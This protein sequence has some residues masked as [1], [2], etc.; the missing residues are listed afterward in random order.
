MYIKSNRKFKDSIRYFFL[1]YSIIPIVISLILFSIFAAALI[2]I[3]IIINTKQANRSIRTNIDKIY[4]NYYDEIN[5]ISES[6][7][8]KSYIKT[9][10]N[11]N[12]VFD[13]YYKFNNKQEV[14]SVLQV[15]D[16][17]NN[18]IISTSY[19]D[20]NFDSE[21]FI[22]NKI[23][24]KIKESSDE[25][26]ID[27]KSI[28]YQ[29]DST[30]ITFAK[31][32]KDNGD[33]IGYAILMIYKSPLESKLFIKN[34]ELSVVTD[35]HNTVILTTN[36]SV[37]GLVNKFTPISVNKKDIVEIEALE[38]GRYFV[39]KF[40]H[41][42][43]G[44]NIYTLNSVEVKFQLFGI[45]I[46]FIVIVSLL[47]WFLLNHLANKM[48]KE[49]TE[50]IDKLVYAV[51]MLKTGDTSYHVDLET[52]DEFE[53]LGDE[54]NSMLDTLN[55]LM[56]KNEELSKLKY[57]SEM[58]LLQSQF[59]PHFIFNVL[60]T[61][62]YSIYI[63][64][65]DTEKIIIKLAKILRYSI[66]YEGD[67][68]TLDK[69]IEYIKDFL[70]LNKFRFGERLTYLINISS[71]AKKSLVPK[72]LIQILVENSIK[73]GYITK[74]RLEIVIT[75]DIV[76][77]KL[78][79]IVSDD[80]PGMNEEKLKKV[81]KV[82]SIAENNSTHI[83]LHNLYRRLGLFYNDDKEFKITSIEGIGTSIKITIPYEKGEGNV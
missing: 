9:M 30:A 49:N 28:K 3:N 7:N 81:E 14:K 21:G 6:E 25:T 2:G 76:N 82:I 54:Y 78:I 59:N 5:N 79:L 11:S 15:V 63:A 68:V 35:K 74:D 64:P 16:T 31:A 23:I 34:N 73:Y 33:I 27:Y 75:A 19:S 8:L 65:K 24:P 47:M 43:S 41:E 71:K 61:L 44:L 72:L 51:N 67:K 39:E 55:L 53:V 70:E 46:A 32:I 10:K 4:N 57:Q 60:E 20:S 17:N 22:L 13:E 26:I 83:G 42:E 29:N 56:D 69:D 12:L 18:F 38:Y 45:Y 36:N 80:G 40:I 66:D 62:R 52:G 50:S 77:E 58:K 1:K 48:S 37:K